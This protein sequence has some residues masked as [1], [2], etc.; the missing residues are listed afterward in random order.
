M[1]R[2]HFFI[3]YKSC[4]SYHQLY[5]VGAWTFR[6]KVCHQRPLSNMYDIRSLTNIPKLTT[7]IIRLWILT[8]CLIID[9]HSITRRNMCIVLLI[10]CRCL[11]I[12]PLALPLNLTYILTVPLK[13]SLGSSPYTNWSKSHNHI[14]SH[15]LFVNRIRP[16]HRLFQNFRN[17]LI[18]R[19]RG[20]V[21]HTQPP[22]R[23]S[24]PYRFS[25][26]GLQCIRSYSPQVGAVLPS[27]TRGRAVLWSQETHL[28]WLRTV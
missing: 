10:K 21:P 8:V 3:R 22:S 14:L 4:P 23:R 13:L 20:F 1:Y 5:P 19:A 11:S 25:V 6:T 12:L 2:K 18:Y 7:D 27:A 26:F 24:T 28:T 16:S 9:S 15:T 17:N